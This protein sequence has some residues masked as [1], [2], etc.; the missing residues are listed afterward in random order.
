MKKSTLQG[1]IEQSSCFEKVNVTG[2]KKTQFDL[3]A[4]EKFY[5]LVRNAESRFRYVF[6]DEDGAGDSVLLEYIK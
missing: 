4:G 5:M 2:E 1:K 6:C 3:E